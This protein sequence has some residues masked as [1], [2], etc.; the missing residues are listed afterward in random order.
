MVC[1]S[2]GATSHN[3]TFEIH[4]GHFIKTTTSLIEGQKTAPEK[5][6]KNPHNIP[7]NRLQLKGL[8]P[9]PKKNKKLGILF[10][11]PPNPTTSSTTKKNPRSLRTFLVR[12]SSAADARCMDIAM[13]SAS[14]AAPRRRRRRRSAPWLRCSVCRARCA[15]TFKADS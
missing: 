14:A 2:V 9:H 15:T 12:S 13:A 10:F 6:P 1:P 11:I 4:K 7:K 8:N 5:C 3:Y